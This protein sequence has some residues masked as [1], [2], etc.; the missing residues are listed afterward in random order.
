MLVSA[1]NMSQKILVRKEDDKEK[2][3]AFLERDRVWA[4]YAICDLE[5][6]LFSLCEWYAAYSNENIISL[7]LYFKG[8][9]TPTQ[10]TFGSGL[11]IGKIFENIDAPKHIYAHFLPTH[12]KAIIEHYSFD[13]LKLMKRM[14]ITK[15]TFTPSAGSASRLT[16]NNLS[17]LK[18][19]YAKHAETFFLPYMLTAG[20]Y[21]GIRKDGMLVSV[22]GTHAS[23][24]IHQIACIGNVFTL[25]SY[26]D[27]GYA[28]ICTSKVVEDLLLSHRDIILNVDSKNVPAIKV[29]KKLGFREHCTYFEGLGTAKC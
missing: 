16:E 19:F 4:G 24:K 28:T 13:K 6:A 17:E 1:Q 29:Y 18:T 11:G 23:S 27:K 25:S 15:E 26:R 14:A 10:I 9:E 2:I 21:Y 8:F 3:L 22:A 20:V 12:K 5:P 7:C